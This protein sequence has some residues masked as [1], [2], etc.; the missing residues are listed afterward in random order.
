[1]KIYLNEYADNIICCYNI[2]LV[3]EQKEL[4]D[5]YMYLN[6]SLNNVKDTTYLFKN[7]EIDNDPK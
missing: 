2:T 4:R 6:F 3:K 7:Y 1:M 5:R